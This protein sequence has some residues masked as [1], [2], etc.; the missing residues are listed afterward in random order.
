M[1]RETSIGVGLHVA[2][3]VID[4]QIPNQVTVLRL[5]YLLRESVAL[6]SV[7]LPEHFELAVINKPIRLNEK[8]VLADYPLGDGD[9]LLV[10][11][12]AGKVEETVL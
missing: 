1:K 2:N 11:E 7:Q 10:R 9:Q 3:R 12:L 6:L 8:A 5:K 4:L